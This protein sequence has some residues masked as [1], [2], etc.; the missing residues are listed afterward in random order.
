MN[1]HISC[2]ICVNADSNWL[3]IYVSRMQ[4]IKRC[5]KG[6]HRDPI[7]RRQKKRKRRGWQPPINLSFSVFLLFD[8]VSS[9][10]TSRTPEKRTALSCIFEWLFTAQLLLLRW[11]KTV[12][13]EHLFIRNMFRL[14]CSV[15]LLGTKSCSTLAFIF[16][17]YSHLETINADKCHTSR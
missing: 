11:F 2:I 3:P 9:V 5:L 6:P 10:H 16:Y 14:F 7:N 8:Y 15:S 13:V 4:S 1:A 12:M 17:I